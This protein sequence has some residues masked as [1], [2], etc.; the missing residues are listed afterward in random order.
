MYANVGPGYIWALMLMG[1]DTLGG[2]YRF[3]LDA[4]Q[5]LGGQ[6][7][8]AT[9]DGRCELTRERWG[10]TSIQSLTRVRSLAV[11]LFEYEGV[12]RTRCGS[13]AGYEFFVQV[14]CV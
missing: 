14:R 6:M 11:V 3:E 13:S 2:G 12:S 4:L 5:D 8:I 10:A 9:G 1:P 7:V